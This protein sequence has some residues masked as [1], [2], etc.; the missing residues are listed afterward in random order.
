VCAYLEDETRAPRLYA[1]LRRYAGICVPYGATANFGACGQYLG[2]LAATMQQWET[3]AAH[4]ESALELNRRLKGLPW[5]ARTQ[6]AYARMLLRRGVREPA[7]HLKVTELLDGALAV[8]QDLN[9]VRLTRQIEALRSAHGAARE[10]QAKP[11]RTA[12]AAPSRALFRL[13]G[14]FWLVGEEAAALHIKDSKGM[15][16]LAHLLQHPGREFHATDLALWDGPDDAGRMLAR[17]SSTEVPLL[18]A[19]A[20][21]EYKRRIGL[22]R[23]Q[24]DEATGFNDVERASR[25]H[26]ELDALT[27]E[28]SR[29]IG[30]HGR[31]RS[32]GSFAERSRLNVTRAIKS[33]VRRIA[34]ESDSIGRYLHTTV[35]TGTFCGYTP[36]PR[37]P[38]EWTL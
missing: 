21:G 34:K 26:E 10:T 36:D 33:V 38:M 23:E 17:A 19:Q 31:D 11:K 37:F 27:H 2:M 24:I 13:E 14:D 4:F 30:L 29:G 28:L 8:A 22:L 9:M 15:R 18:D 6:L 25:L 1:L 3:A 12:T 7:D 35:R 32:A 16:Y 20:K 5:V